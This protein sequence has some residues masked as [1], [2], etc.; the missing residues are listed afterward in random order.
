MKLEAF[1][2]CKQLSERENLDYDMIKSINDSIFKSLN[3]TLR[4]SP[5]LIA[6]VDDLGIF[7]YRKKKT[8]D[9]LRFLKEDEIGY[10]EFK[11]S[12]ERIVE[13]YKQFDKDKLEFKYE[14][15]GKEAHEAYLLDK[16]QKG[17]FRA[18][19]NKPK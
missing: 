3:V 16:K 17:L 14:Q 5:N 4:K 13:H 1:N 10:E 11:E 2:I 15:F 9:K 6:S 12:L 7:Y 19:E 8:L 18:K